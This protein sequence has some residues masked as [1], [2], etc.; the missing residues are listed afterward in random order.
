MAALQ[1]LPGPSSGAHVIAAT[2]AL[3]TH[4]EAQRRRAGETEIIKSRRFWTVGMDELARELVEAWRAQRNDGQAPDWGSMVVALQQQAELDQST[5][6]VTHKS[7]RQHCVYV[8]QW[9]KKILEILK[10]RR[11]WTTGMDLKRSVLGELQ[12]LTEGLASLNERCKQELSHEDA[13]NVHAAFEAANLELDKKM[14]EQRVYAQQQCKPVGLGEGGGARTG[15]HTSL[16]FGPIIAY[17]GA[18]LGFR[19]CRCCY[20]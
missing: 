9:D 15:G 11:F 3:S 5:V 1:N 18:H 6:L 13:L 8:M 20:C 16:G 14:E 4:Q 12:A 7:I 2:R 17:S 19:R 10:S